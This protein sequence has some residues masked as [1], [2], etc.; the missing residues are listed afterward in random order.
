[1]L[2]GGTGSGSSITAAQNTAFNLVG[3]SDF[4]IEAWIY[5]S[6][7]QAGDYYL[8]V[9]Q[10][11]LTSL[12]NCEWGVNIYKGSAQT[13]GCIGF[14]QSI[15]N[16]SG[17]TVSVTSAG[18]Y[19]SSG[20]WTHIALSVNSGVM[21]VYKNG[22]QIT[23]YGSQSLLYSG[24]GNLYIGYGYTS[25]GNN[26]FNG[27]ISNVRLIKGTGLYPSGTT[28]TAPAIPLSAVTNTSLLACRND[29]IIDDS[30]NH[31]TLTATS[32]SVSSTVP[33]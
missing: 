6:A 10:K 21:Y 29:T 23:N 1:V 20:V 8:P 28:F 2:F 7:W 31:F 24:T 25:Q 33:N 26:S 17:V 30:T 14:A 3:V 16:T 18:T 5:I 4:T 11:G 9:I 13:Q 19:I 32:V 27:Y 22:V 12:S 15:S